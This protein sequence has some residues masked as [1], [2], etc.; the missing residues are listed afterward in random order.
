[1][2][3]TGWELVLLFFGAIIYGMYKLTQSPTGKYVAM[4]ITIFMVWV[5]GSVAIAMTKSIPNHWIGMWLGVYWTGVMIWW[6]YMIHLRQKREDQVAERYGFTKDE[7]KKFTDAQLK[8][9]CEHI[10]ADYIDDTAED[11]PK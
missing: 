6:R 8:W 10:S 9:I 4:C 5:I 1:M 11:Y 2:N 7:V 3:A